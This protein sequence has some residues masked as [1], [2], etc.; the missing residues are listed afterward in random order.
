[1]DW[2][3]GWAQEGMEGR[4]KIC[5]SYHLDGRLRSKGRLRGGL[6]HRDAG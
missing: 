2:M 3:D 1:M 4:A 5:T 6:A